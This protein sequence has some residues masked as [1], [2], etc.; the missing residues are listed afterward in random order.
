MEGTWWEVD[1]ELRG[2]QLYIGLCRL[3]KL[4]FV[5]GVIAGCHLAEE[6]IPAGVSNLIFVRKGWVNISDKIFF[7]LLIQLSM[8]FKVNWVGER[9]SHVR[10]LFCAGCS[11]I[12][13]NQHRS[14]LYEACEIREGKMVQETTGWFCIFFRSPMLCFVSLFTDA[15]QIAGFASCNQRVFI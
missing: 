7:F 2:V 3:L 11:C 6:M 8:C 1:A 5:K 9:R 10:V 14:F 12:W 15:W 4:S 13:V